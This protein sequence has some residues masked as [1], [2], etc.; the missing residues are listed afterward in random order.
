MNAPQHASQ[1]GFR[2]TV[3]QMSHCSCR[4]NCMSWAVMASQR[5][6][7]SVDQRM[8]QPSSS[9]SSWGWRGDLLGDPRPQLPRNSNSNLKYRTG[10]ASL[11]YG[12]F[13]LWYRQLTNYCWKEVSELDWALCPSGICWFDLFHC[14]RSWM[15]S[16]PPCCGSLNLASSPGGEWPEDEASLNSD[17]SQLCA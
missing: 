10:M 7:C 16:T 5:A 13:W 1:V 6:M 8:W 11:L 2:I 4:S 17:P 3:H 15:R 14:W 9:R 12:G